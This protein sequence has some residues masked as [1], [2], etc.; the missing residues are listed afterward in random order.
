MSPLQ[1][2][3]DD[4]DFILLVAFLLTLGAAA[5]DGKKNLEVFLR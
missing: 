1:L 3:C 2:R 5:A 4:D